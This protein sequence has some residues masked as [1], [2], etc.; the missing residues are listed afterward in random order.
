MPPAARL[1]D[2]T[3]VL[4]MRDLTVRLKTPAGPLK[5]LDGVSLQIGAGQ[6]LGLVGESGCGKSV[7]SLAIMRLLPAHQVVYETGEIWF[8]GRNLLALT[9]RNMR[10]LR[11]RDIAM[12]FQ[13]PMT[14]LN[15]VLTVGEQIAESLRLHRGIRGLAARAEATRLLDLVG[16][17]GAAQRVNAYPHE[18]SGGQRQR[19]MI[20]MAL[21]CQPKLLIADEPTTALDVTVQ[22]Q[23]LRLLDDLR[24]EFQMAMLLISHDLGLVSDHCDAVA[25]MYAGRIAER[26][27][28][29]A[30]FSRPAHPYTEALLHTAP[31]G[32]P[33]GSIL[34]TIPGAVPALTQRGANCHFQSRCGF[35]GDACH[36]APPLSPLPGQ[37]DAEQV[38]CWHPRGAGPAAQ[39]TNADSQ[40][41]TAVITASGA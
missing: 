36:K 34:P 26:R 41:D 22:A 15:P 1:P 10:S 37:S 24:R 8:Q 3:H 21:A 20:A 33:P 39:A 40:Q 18:M 14:S 12:I 35:A 4:D 17:A 23:I 13:E 25:V 19:V 31:S 7:T 11:G 32:H 27:S 29:A 6:T 28:T 38:A 30:L 16:I 2:E 9:E 5:V